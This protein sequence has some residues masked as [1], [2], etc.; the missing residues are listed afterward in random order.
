MGEAVKQ[1]SVVADQSG[2]INVT[3]T[4]HMRRNGSVYA[5]VFMVPE[6]S[7]LRVI[8]EKHLPTAGHSVTASSEGDEIESDVVTTQVLLEDAET[9][10]QTCVSA[11]D[12][13]NLAALYRRVPMIVH[14]LKKPPKKLRMLL[15]S[16]HG[17]AKLQK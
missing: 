13:V 5:H 12:I 6:S 17:E 1:S 11:D 2:S 10:A 3:V 4:D 9:G 16:V 14:R 8:F 15:E 7:L